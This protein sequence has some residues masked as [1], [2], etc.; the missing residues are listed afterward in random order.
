M[1]NYINIREGTPY[2]LGAKW[3]GSGVNFAIYSRNAE[4]VYL[5][6]FDNEYKE[7]LCIPVRNRTHYIWHCY[8]EGIRP[9]QLYG[10]RIGGPY[11]P[12]EGYR[13]NPA[14]ILLD[15]YTLAI[16]RD[17]I[18]STEHFGYQYPYKFYEKDNR[19]NS[20]YALLGAVMDPAF[21]WGDDKQLKIPW[22]DT[23]IYEVHV[24]GFTKL[25]HLIPEQ[26]RGT[27]LAFTTEPV[28][29]YLK[30]LG[31][32]TLE[33]LPV[34]HS[35]TEYHLY[36][37][38]K[39]NYWGYN[40]IAFFAPNPKYAYSKSID[41]VIN[42]FKTMVKVLHQAGFEVI[43]DVVYNHTAEGDHT[44]PTLSFRGIDNLSYYRVYEEQK[45]LYID[46]TGCGN[47]LNHQNHYVLQL[48]MDSLRYWV[49]EMHVDGFRFDLASALARE[50]HNVD[51]LNSFFAIVQQDPVISRV[52][53]IAEPWD[54][55]KD[56]YQVGNFPPGWSEW[57]GKYRDTIRKVINGY[58][59]NLSDFA[60]RIAGSSDLYKKDD[61]KT[62]SSIN[63][64]TC[65]DG[66]TLRDLV[67]YNQKHNL[68]NGWNNLDGTDLNFSNNYGVE[69]DT[70]DLKIKLLRLKK[71][72][73]FLTTLFISQGVPM[74]LA[75]DELNRTQKGNNNPYCQDNE[76]S[77]I[78]WDLDE[79]SMEL[80]ITT[81]FLIEL[82]K[83][84]EVFR[85]EEFFR[86]EENK[87]MEVKDIYWLHPDGREMQIEDWQKELCIGV[88]L[89]SEF[90][91]RFDFYTKLTG[92]TFL[93]LFNF[94]NEKVE[95]KIPEM[96]PTNWK[97]IFSTSK[98]LII[99]NTEDKLK[100]IHKKYI[101]NEFNKNYI[102]DKFLEEIE[103]LMANEEK[104]YI[105]GESI[106]IPEDTIIILKADKNWKDINVR[107]NY[108][109]RLLDLLCNELG[110]YTKFTDLQNKEYQLTHNE[111]YMVLRSLNLPIKDL[112]SLEVV[113]ESYKN[114]IFFY[115]M[116]PTI[117]LSKQ[118]K[119][120]LEIVIPET[121]NMFLFR[122]VDKKNNILY[123]GE[124][125][126][127]N[128]IETH[129]IVF[130]QF[131]KLKLIKIQIDLDISLEYGYYFFEIINKNEIL[132]RGKLIIVPDSAYMDDNIYTGIWIQ[133]YALRSQTNLGIGDFG[134][135]KKLSLKIKQYGYN[136]IG[137]SPLHYLSINQSEN[138]S[139]YY[140]SS[141]LF[142]HP[143]YID[144]FS[145]E[146]FHSS[147]IALNKWK[148]NLPL[149]EK[150][151]NN[152]LIN[153]KTVY[154]IK[155]E[156]L[157][158]IY[159][160]FIS[161]EKYRSKREEFNQY[162]KDNDLLLYHALYETVIEVFGKIRPPEDIYS[163]ESKTQKEFIEGH[164]E[165]I[166]F[167]SYLF[168]VAEK[169]FI[170]LVKELKNNGIY[171]YLDLALGS[172]PE[173]I[174]SIYM[175]HFYPNIFSKN[176]RAGAPPDP[177]S[178]AGQDWGIT[179]LNPYLLKRY[180][181]EPY[182]LLLE[183]NL[184][185]DVFL[186][187]DHIMW[188]YRLFWIVKEG[189]Q[190]TS[191]YIRY[192]DKDLFGILSLESQKKSAI[193][194]GED[195]GTIPED[196][197]EIMKNKKIL[198]WKVFYFEKYNEEYIDPKNYPILSVATINTHDLPTLAGF[199]TGKDIEEKFKI[200]LFKEEEYKKE[201]ENRTKER[202]KIIQLF[203]KKG[204]F[205]DKESITEDS[206]YGPE[207][208]Y[209]FYRLLSEAPSRIL[210]VSLND[211]LGET[212]APNIPGTTTEYPSWRIR[213]S[214]NIEELDEN[215][216]FKKIT[217]ALNDRLKKL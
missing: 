180:G 162:K 31:V 70:L 28:I 145:L 41:G 167:Y 53:L 126:Q 204:Y 1:I 177:F 82:R 175:D 14:K 155:K 72:K 129:T 130:S 202:K 213:Y 71:Q 3:D 207:I 105:Q 211:L 68:D 45:E 209:Y 30:D 11:N 97:I 179:V 146:E 158:E 4:Y 42:E 109:L 153:Y 185:N 210:L 102:N 87:V 176:A 205:K 168:F 187:I 148:E 98:N 43:L 191:T 140:P 39:V 124:I 60:T 27:Y 78:H 118:E 76:L 166:D 64:I 104:N 36:K 46:F 69:G 136:I 50:L 174:E 198:S 125:S 47:T 156:I 55:G 8:V 143:M 150:E 135:L 65:H 152:T 123:S 115:E 75:G 26:L 154:R 164:K 131:R 88:L 189:N 56:G 33:F 59:N 196:F 49:Q 44:G 122:L 165:K 85:R 133:L 110:I 62:Y 24:K 95:F 108:R 113:Y 157:Y 200:G 13:F 169:Q 67:S 22:K 96:I 81:R 32:T 127:Y 101:T 90:G 215:P 77:Y 84:N 194:I 147:K 206:I 21:S 107:K 163:Y 121:L 183:K 160:E 74:L 208:A 193:I 93:I 116:Q 212:D 34:Q 161:N 6:L 192:P 40:P 35:I 18:W 17:L 57:N 151:K 54:L 100:F 178:P 182:R 7:S 89:P 119:Y 141:R 20:R 111:L 52:K 94:S 203:E 19:D 99:T 9:G 61:R 144:I 171:L 217:L 128:I 73:L 188:F 137:I 38:K 48:I 112:S 10:Y 58:E 63:F 190:K 195:L 114:D 201:M 51:R 138:Y 5:C 29:R 83:K 106:S 15:P 172:N 184:F 159:K 199:W 216:Y 25:N 37:S 173:Q 181:F 149:I 92:D 16:G 12:R 197:R 142:I 103:T 134:D 23:I 120:R 186:R 139:P 66:F 79:F 117:I 80:L 214:V 132:N 2:P 86:G 91:E 170:D